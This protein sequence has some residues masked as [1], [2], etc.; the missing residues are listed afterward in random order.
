MYLIKFDIY[1]KDATNNFNCFENVIT[2]SSNQ[3]LETNNYNDNYI[4]ELFYLFGG[5]IA[6]NYMINDNINYSDFIRYIYLNNI[7]TIL[8][9]LNKES[10]IKKFHF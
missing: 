6:N 2:T 4:K 5:I 1:K 10:N 3:I 7:K 9:D 8:K